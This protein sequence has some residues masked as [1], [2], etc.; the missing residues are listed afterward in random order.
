MGSVRCEAQPNKAPGHGIV[1][2]ER[3]ASHKTRRGD[4]DGLTLP[5]AESIRFSRMEDDGGLRNLLLDCRGS[6]AEFFRTEQPWKRDKEQLIVS[7]FI[8]RGGILEEPDP[9]IG[10]RFE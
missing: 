1:R 5:Q 2:L 3:Q 7:A 6:C 4:V 10:L 9:R 8:T